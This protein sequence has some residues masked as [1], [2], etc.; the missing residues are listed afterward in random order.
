[1]PKTYNDIYF[2]VRSQLRDSGVSAY[3]LEARILVAAAAGKNT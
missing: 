2:Y 1:M 3:A